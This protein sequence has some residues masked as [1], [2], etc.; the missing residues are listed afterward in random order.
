MACDVWRDVSP[1]LLARTVDRVCRDGWPLPA[2]VVVELD[3]QVRLPVWWPRR[4]RA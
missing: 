1:A 4:R 2:P 3:G